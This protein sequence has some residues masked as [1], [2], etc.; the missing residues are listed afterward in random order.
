VELFNNCP[1][2]VELDARDTNCGDCVAIRACTDCKFIRLSDQELFLGAALRKFQ[3]NFGDV[4]RFCCYTHTLKKFRIS[5]LPVMALKCPLLHALSL[6]V[7]KELTNK[8]LQLV[9][10]RCPLL[11]N[12]SLNNNECE[13]LDGPQLIKDITDFCPQLHT[14]M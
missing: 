8:Q 7:Y 1:N 4:D 14:L 11:A 2:L 6:C 13:V 3:N 12:F 9:F 5:C 10:K